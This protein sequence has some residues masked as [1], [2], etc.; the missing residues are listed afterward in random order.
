VIAKDIMSEN[1]KTVSEDTPIAAVAELLQDNDIR[2]VPVVRDGELIG[3][4]SDRDLRSLMIPRLVDEKALSEIRAQYH[5]PVSSLMSPDVISVNPETELREIVEL[6]LEYKVGAVPVVD[7]S[8]GDLVGIV[9]YVDVL[10]GT[11]G[12]LG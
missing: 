11:L 6:M 8:S 10:R 12:E 3:I 4:L 1:P 5:A 7:P 9:S 2:H